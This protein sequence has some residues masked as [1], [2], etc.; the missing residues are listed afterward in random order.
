VAR[1]T[2]QERLTK[3]HDEALAEFD[4][5]QSSVRDERLQALQDRRFVSIA[6]AQWEGPLGEQFANKPKF[7]VNKIA[8]S[9]QRIMS[10]YRANRITVD[11]IAKDGEYDQLADVCD[12]LYR[13][14]EQDSSAEEAYD[15]AFEEAL[16]GGFGAWRLRTVYESEEDDEDERQRIRI[17]PIFDADSSVFFDLQAKRQDKADARLCFVLTSMTHAAY[18][19]AYGESPSSWPKEVHQYEFDWATPDVVFVA[20]YY[21]I[22]DKAETVHVYRSLDGE[23][24]RYRSDEL[25]D[26][27]MAEL[28]AIGSVEVRQKRVKRR[29]VHKYILSGARVLEDCGYLPGRYIPIVPVYGKRWFIDNVERFSGHVR[30]AKD[31]QRLANMQRSAL[32]EISA[33]STIE[34]P[35]FVPE[36]IAGHQVMWEQDN[37]KNYP[38]LLVNPIT[39]PDGSMQA[40]GPV[41]YTKAPSVPQAMAALLQLTEQDIR[42]VLGGQEQGDKLTANTSGKAVELVQGRL[43]MQTFLFM[44]NFG[45]GQRRCGEIWLSMARE[46]YVEPGR[47]MKR[48]GQRAEI[49]SVELM[50][51]MIG[52]DGEIEYENDLS[53]AEFDVAVEVG[54]SS[55]SKRA[56]TVRALTS[57]M[58]VTSDPQA[59]KILQAAV[60][61]NMDGEGLA[62]IREFFRRQ[63]VQIGVIKPSEEEAAQMQ[64]TQKEDP[65]EVFLKA[66]AEEAMAK[67]A[68]AN[69]DVIKTIAESEL[70][71]AKTVETLGKAGAAESFPAAQSMAVQQQVDQGVATVSAGGMDER[72]QLQLEAM[73]LENEIKRRQLMEQDAMLERAYAERDALQSGAESS[74]GMR[75]VVSGLGESVS[76]ISDAVGQMREAIGTL[77]DSNAANAERA[78]QAL[79]KPK[80]IVR[81]RGRIARI[82]TDD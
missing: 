52:D 70:T 53:E 5:I 13:A 22:E 42:D 2:E 75:E 25:T 60:L 4:R 3:V 47:K 17:E 40:G 73:A 23:E 39:A 41:G 38:Y 77:A 15:N 20:E 72:T 61:M 82:E 50:R 36:Q 29:R 28:D 81:E 37:L 18:E 32:A 35:I 54:P 80:R 45:K 26:E 33:L 6:G 79:A 57:M 9:V 55:S 51:P 24:E 65:N 21:R 59:Q 46:T 34:K 64:A 16:T 63:L 1:P 49:D 27:V 11:F 66:A 69:A 10:E 48:I 19:D 31:A 56:A 12:D 68:K 62:D 76:A 44:S 30:L 67:A 74:N 43:D 78:L 14:D 7:E 71:Q 8:M 58:A